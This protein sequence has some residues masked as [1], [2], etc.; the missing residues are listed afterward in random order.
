ML[1]YLPRNGTIIANHRPRFHPDK[2]PDEK[3]DDS[4][5]AVKP[6]MVSILGLPSG[7]I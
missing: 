7:V 2:V 5:L 4:L 1:S 6:V 3:K